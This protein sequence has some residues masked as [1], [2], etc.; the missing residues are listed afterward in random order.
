[1]VLYCQSLPFG[2]RKVGGD[3]H[4][5]A[6]VAIKG[7][8]ETMRSLLSPIAKLSSTARWSIGWPNKMAPFLQMG[9]VLAPNFSYDL[10]RLYGH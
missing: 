8:R 7:F 5:R 3:W 10:A 2:A 9:A 6:S 4:Q 1:M